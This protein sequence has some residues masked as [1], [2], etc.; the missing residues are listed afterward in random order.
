VFEKKFFRRGGKF[1]LWGG[2]VK[3]VLG[4]P[5]G[6][7]PIFGGGVLNGGVFPRGGGNFSKGHSGALFFTGGCIP[8]YKKGPKG[9]SFLKNGGFFF[10]KR[11]HSVVKK[12]FFFLSR[13]S[14]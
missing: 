14:L 13:P 10:M 5:C 8:F 7:A 3:K 12:D 11:A 2:G 6:G 4:E 9:A 1:P